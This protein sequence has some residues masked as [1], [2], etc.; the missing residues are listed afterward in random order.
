[1]RDGRAIRERLQTS[2]P[3]PMLLRVQRHRCVGM[4]GRPDRAGMRGWSR[5][6]HSFEAHYS[7]VPAHRARSILL[8]L[9]TALEYVR[10][11]TKSML[12]ILLFICLPAC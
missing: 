3:K 12:D 1:M 8:R 6:S 5:S 2:V 7:S 10:G 11:T 4:T 9:A